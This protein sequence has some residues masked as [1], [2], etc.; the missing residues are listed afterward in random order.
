MTPPLETERLILR[1]LETADC[2][3]VLAVFADAYARSFYPDMTT[4]DAARAWIAQNRER[5]ARD[6][7]GLWAMV[8]RK[9]GMV[10]GDCG[11]TWQ[12]VGGRRV[13]EIGYHVAP[14][15]RGHGFAL[16][17]ASEA[18]AFGFN[19]TGEAMI[20]SIVAPNNTASISV[21]RRLHREV[22]PYVNGRG[23]DRLLFFT[24]REDWVSGRSPTP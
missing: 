23:L 16:E 14:D 8:D 9:T 2:A 19:R 5:Y 12:D 18:M 3:V 11:P 21:A 24:R 20:G 22:M 10:I 6:G 15:W 13:L 7:F 4:Q 1:D 17:A